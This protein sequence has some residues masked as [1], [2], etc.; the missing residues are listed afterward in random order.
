MEQS[1]NCNKCHVDKELAQ[2]VGEDGKP[3]AVCADCRLIAKFTDYKTRARGFS[4]EEGN[5][6]T[7]EWRKV[8]AIY[9][10]KCL[11]CGSTENITPDH[12]IPLSEKGRNVVANIQPLCVSCN[13]AKKD[14]HDYRKRKR[15]SYEPLKAEYVTSNISL[16]EL[17]EKYNLTETLLFKHSTRDNW[18]KE[19]QEYGS[20]VVAETRR[21]AI[22]KDVSAR[23]MILD[24]ARTALEEWKS[25]PKTNTAQL[26]QILELA[27]R[28]EGL[29]L[30]KRRLIVQDWRDAAG[31]NVDELDRFADEAANRIL[32]SGA[33]GDSGEDSGSSAGWTD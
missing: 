15:K 7:D 18:E 19:R 17:A 23:V 25:S 12:V 27:A 14:A 26:A 33:A 22:S 5:F 28:V 29:E 4:G 30:D 21:A 31:D 11:K 10:N 24:A 3:V 20:K 32:G 9:G 6:S 2:F 16:R 13:K 1:K 8:L